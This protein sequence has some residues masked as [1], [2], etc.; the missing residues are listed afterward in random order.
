MIGEINNNFFSDPLPRFLQR[1]I[2]PSLFEVNYIYHRSQ[3]GFPASVPCM[4]IIVPF[5]SS[6]YDLYIMYRQDTCCVCLQFDQKDLKYV[7]YYRD[8]TCSIAPLLG[9]ELCSLGFKI[10]NSFRKVTHHMQEEIHGDVKHITQIKQLNFVMKFS[11]IK[12][13][14]S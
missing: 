9:F 8:T 10:Y 5:P 6:L 2:N 11:M 1:V 3:L 14:Q 12:E 7:L 4:M 13:A